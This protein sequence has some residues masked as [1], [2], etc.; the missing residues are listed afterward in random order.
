L[1]PAV[2]VVDDF[3]DLV[4]ILQMTIEDV[5]DLKVVGATSFKQVKEI[6]FDKYQYKLAILDINLGASEPN[7][8][9]VF[10]FLKEKGFMGEIIFFT[11]HAEN[12]PLVKEAAKLN[13]VRIVNKP[14]RPDELTSI[15]RSICA[16]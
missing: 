2:L 15:I 6:D 1:I 9:D 14:I 3:E 12:H 5:C 4:E 11:G 8:I 13:G 7:G 10:H 16:S